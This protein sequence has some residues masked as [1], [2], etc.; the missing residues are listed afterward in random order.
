MEYNIYE[1][2]A[3]VF[4]N[5]LVQKLHDPDVYIELNF[6][7]QPEEQN[8][9]YNLTDTNF[10]DNTVIDIKCQNSVLPYADYISI[11]KFNDKI[12]YRCQLNL[13]F[14]EWHESIS[15]KSFVLRLI[16]NAQRQKLDL[17]IIFV[18]DAGYCLEFNTFALTENTIG[19]KI[20]N[21]S[22][23]LSALISQTIS[24]QKS[25]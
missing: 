9:F 6:I 18:E 19:D 15:L 3:L 1:E 12:N 25:Q 22:L 7:N 11:E 23:K 13:Y 4:K 24:E 21:I 20:Q 8:K 10:P 2:I 14:N 5:S 17:E 16:A